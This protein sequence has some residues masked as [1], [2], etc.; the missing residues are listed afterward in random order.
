[1]TSERAK[2]ANRRN[3]QASTGPRTAS[4]KQRVSQNARSHGLSTAYLMP[5]RTKWSL[6]WLS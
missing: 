4:G 1:M 2:S 5:L 6:A 3:A